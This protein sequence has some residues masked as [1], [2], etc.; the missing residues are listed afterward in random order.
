MWSEYDWYAILYLCHNILFEFTWPDARKISVNVHITYLYR[1]SINRDDGASMVNMPWKLIDFDFQLSEAISVRFEQLFILFLRI[2]I[3]CRD[4]PSCICIQLIGWD[5]F[6]G[7]Y[8]ERADKSKVCPWKFK[9]SVPGIRVIWRWKA[10]IWRE[11]GSDEAQ[12]RIN[13]NSIREDY[14][15]PSRRDEKDLISSSFQ[16]FIQSSEL[17]ETFWLKYYFGGRPQSQTE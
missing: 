9:A 11:K 15:R 3:R 17:I 16:G 6:R 2:R 14:L 1:M 10:I 8:A 12:G 7:S 4:L 5:G 13:Y